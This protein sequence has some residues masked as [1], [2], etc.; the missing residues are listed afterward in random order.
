MRS[1]SSFYESFPYP[2]LPVSEKKDVARHLH[3]TVMKRI[4]ASANLMP[5]NLKNKSVL[6]AGCGTGEKSAY[7]AMHGAKAIGIDISENS[8]SLAKSNAKKFKVDGKCNFQKLDIFDLPKHF[9]PASFHHI[10]SIGVI[11][12]TE[13]PEKCVEIFSELLKPHGT[14]TLG[15]YHLYGRLPLRLHRAYIKAITG[16]KMENGLR[17]VENS[18][19]RRPL[20]SDMEKAYLADTYLHPY[21][22]YHSIGEVKGWFSSANLQFIGTMPKANSFFDE[23]NWLMQRKGFFFI[24]SRKP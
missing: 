23:L 10:F 15:L 8:L 3:E 24:S 20:K 6:D 12:H 7:F 1:V 13:N 2:Q 9:P 22:S 4:L 19:L 17:H 16:G 18:I 14:L 21:E 11:H 5:A